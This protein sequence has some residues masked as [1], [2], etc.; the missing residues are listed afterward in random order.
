MVEAPPSAATRSPGACSKSGTTTTSRS[1][2]DQLDGDHDWRG[3]FESAS[4]PTATATAMACRRPAASILCWCR[5][6]STRTTAPKPFA[7]HAAATRRP[8]N[9]LTASYRRPS[10]RAHPRDD[11]LPRDP[12]A[13]GAPPRDPRRDPHRVAHARLPRRQRRVQAP[14]LR[15]LRARPRTIGRGTTMMGPTSHSAVSMD[16]LQRPFFTPS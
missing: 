15:G 13:V 7:V 14:R 6:Y 11:H 10:R 8:A 16:Q 4:R 2:A 12:H 9:R 5:W 3:G 1:T